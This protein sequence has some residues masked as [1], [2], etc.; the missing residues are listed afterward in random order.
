M[1]IP[2]R[3]GGWRGAVSLLAVVTPSGAQDPID[4]PHGLS[5]LLQTQVWWEQCWLLLSHRQYVPT[6]TLLTTMITAGG[7]GFAICPENPI[8]LEIES[9]CVLNLPVPLSRPRTS[10][11]PGWI[12]QSGATIQKCPM[13]PCSQVYSVVLHWRCRWGWHRDNLPYLG[14]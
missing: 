7:W 11:L 9:V 6:N 1:G 5:C 3:K 12:A 2:G 10:L 4:V 13:S 14:L 8:G